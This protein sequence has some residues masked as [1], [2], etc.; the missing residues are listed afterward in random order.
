MPDLLKLIKYGQTEKLF[1][2]HNMKL[3]ISIEYKTTWGEEL[4]L[5]LG[6]KRH[7]MSYTAEGVW[8]LELPRFNAA[9]PVE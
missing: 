9:Q 6:G 1:K 8:K 4:V 5:C 2:L 3:L 7:P